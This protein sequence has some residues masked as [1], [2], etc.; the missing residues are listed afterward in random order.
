MQGPGHSSKSAVQAS[1]ANTFVLTKY[2]IDQLPPYQY[3]PLPED[4]HPWIRVMALRPSRSREAP[5][6][7]DLIHVIRGECPYE[8]LSYAW[9]DPADK[10][11]MLVRSSANFVNGA[12]GSYVTSN[13]VMRITQN[14]HAALLFLRFKRDPQ[15]FWIDAV[16][17]NQADLDEKQRHIVLMGSIYSG[18]L[19]TRIWV[20]E[21]DKHTR[22]LFYWMRLI[23]R[24]TYSRLGKSTRDALDK[25]F[26]RN[27]LDRTGNSE[28]G[29]WYLWIARMGEIIFVEGLFLNLANFKGT[30]QD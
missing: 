7:C 17:I 24:V 1:D 3:L 30:I 20:G 6:E 26:R 12:F 2:D 18:A 22:R 21:A 15:C 13:T 27:I 10:L 9:G 28:Y 5:L 25:T 19:Q 16:C 11:P 14:L 8:A 4:G 23:H 29:L